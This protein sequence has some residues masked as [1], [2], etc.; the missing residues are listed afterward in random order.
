M[1]FVASHPFAKNAN[2]ARCV[3]AGFEVGKAEFLDGFL[4]TSECV[5]SDR[6]AIR[7]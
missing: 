3:C 1:R 2:G 7:K 6:S 5:P 4:E